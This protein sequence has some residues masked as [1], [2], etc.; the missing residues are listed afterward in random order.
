M[1]LYGIPNMLQDW[2]EKKSKLKGEGYMHMYYFSNISGLLIKV[3]LL[4]NVRLPHNA[5]VFLSTRI[6]EPTV[7]SKKSFNNLVMGMVFLTKTSNYE[8]KMLTI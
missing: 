2:L 5:L 4:I 6:T 3:P 7:K 8:K 1:L